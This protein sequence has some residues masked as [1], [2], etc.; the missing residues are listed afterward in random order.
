VAEFARTF[1][2]LENATRFASHVSFQE[3]SAHGGEEESEEEGREE[4]GR[5]EKEWREPTIGN[6]EAREA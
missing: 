2:A 6:E 1:V 3:D 4:E 5:E